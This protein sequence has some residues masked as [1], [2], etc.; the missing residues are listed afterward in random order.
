MAS[1]T[2]PM[3]RSAYNP[4]QSDTVDLPS[5]ST[6]GIW[7]GASGDM[8]VTMSSGRVMLYQAIP[9]GTF[10]GIEVTRVWDSNTTLSNAQIVIQTA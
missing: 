8:Q 6:A 7:V 10:L 1:P 5:P 4:V 9:A 3:A 2:W